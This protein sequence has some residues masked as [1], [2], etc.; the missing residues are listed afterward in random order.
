MSLLFAHGFR[1]GGA[2]RYEDSTSINFASS[3]GFNNGIDSA[4]LQL[5]TNFTSYVRKD[6]PSRSTII[7]GYRL[8]LPVDTFTAADIC[9]FS[10]NTVVHM[11]FRLDI[12]TFRITAVHGNG[13]I[14]GVSDPI[15][16]NP[17]EFVYLEF[18]VTPDDSAGAIEVR[19]FGVPRLV[20]SG[21]DTRN[22]GTAGITRNWVG[23]PT[24]SGVRPGL[25]YDDLYI[26]DTL[27]ATNND[28]LATAGPPGYTP[29]IID[30]V[31]NAAGDSTDWAAT[32]SGGVNWAA[33]ADSGS[34]PNNDTSY[35][36]AST[37]GA[38]DL[39]NLGNLP[40]GASDI[41][42]LVQWALWRKDDATIRAAAMTAR[43]GATDSDDASVGLTNSYTLKER[44]LETD[45]A[46]SA[47][48]TESGVN[49]FQIGQKVTA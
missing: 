32:G 20:L 40:A 47:A 6:C 21:I 42:G 44:V 22:G 23:R 38:K 39:Y 49:A 29:R 16:S 4:C 5:T 28:F 11:R 48:F 25:I 15:A 43:S 2:A 27:G 7:M 46:T 10:D 1:Y 14:L 31:P 35:V 24:S 33:V 17:S 45:P 37:V 18:K 30:L 26:C 36:A 12:T 13:T 41:R 9:A 34:A 3:G 8:W 19:G